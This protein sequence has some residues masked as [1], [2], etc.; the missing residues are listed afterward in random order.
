VR[1]VSGDRAVEEAFG[2][3]LDAERARSS[4]RLSTF[5]VAAA[6]AML[7]ASAV[8]GATGSDA[9]AAGVPWASLWLAGALVWLLA[10]RARPRLWRAGRYLPLLYDFPILYLGYR[11]VIAAAAVPSSWFGAY[12]MTAAAGLVITGL[13]LDRLV[14]AV[15]SIASIAGTV[16]LAVERSAAGPELVVSFALILAVAGAG[17]WMVIERS[18]HLARKFAGEQVAA[19][20]LGRHFSPAVARRIIQ[21][22]V[23]AASETREVTVLVADL[24]GFTA[25]SERL[26]RAE[27]VVALLNQLLGRMVDVVFEHGGT[28]DKFLGDGLLAYFGAPLPQEDHPVRAVSC[29]LAMQAALGELNRERERRGE[30][31]LGMGIG[32]HTGDVVVG[33]IGPENRREYTVI[34]DPVN[35]TA[36]IEGLTKE[37][38]QPVLASEVTRARVADVEWRPVGARPVRGKAEPIALFAPV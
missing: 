33:D 7:A 32:I 14:L 19:V 28:L 35:V 38:G 11:A 37:V 30:G 25:E 21:S 8:G 5:R 4:P 23:Q 17:S 36:R 22:G 12:G 24:R 3:S 26:G 13:T 16:G 27:E 9:L 29:A 6:V 15:M 31:R 2:R 1:P 18:E 20:E 34:G 10:L